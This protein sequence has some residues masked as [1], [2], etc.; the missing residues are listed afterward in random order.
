MK[1]RLLIGL[2]L[3]VALVWVGQQAFD[4]HLPQSGSPPC[5]F[6]NQCRQDLRRALCASMDQAKR[7]IHLATFTLSD[8]KI[9]EALRRAAERGVFVKVTMDAR[10]TRGVVR[11]LGEQIELIPKKGRGLMHQKLLVIDGQVLWLGSANMTYSSLR[12]FGNLV[13][14]IENPKLAQAVQQSMGQEIG[15]D[16]HLYTCADQRIE[17]WQL[18]A[19]QAAL[20]RLIQLIDEA[21]YRIRIAMFT[22]THA[23]LTAAVIRAHER[24]LIVEVVIDKPSGRG[25][26]RKTIVKLKEAGIHVSLDI[27]PQLLHHKLAWI[28]NSLVIGSANWTAS[29]FQKNCDCFLIVHDLNP[30]QNRQLQRLWKIIS[31]ESKSA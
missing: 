24:G 12:T 19:D 5:L 17:Y 13:V 9:I 16:E 18:P 4:P 1:K 25:A 10:Q 29:A 2:V 15:A 11:K 30:R 3:L 7:S 31:L 26:S 8:P 14:W 6:A 28:D 22:W 23:Q 27:G 20:T 21:R